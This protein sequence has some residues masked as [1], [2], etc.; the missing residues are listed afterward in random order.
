MTTALLRPTPAR[1]HI[2][3]RFRKIRGRG[4][5]SRRQR[6][7]YPGAGNTWRRCSL[8]FLRPLSL[9]RTSTVTL[10]TRSSPLPKSK[11]HAAATVGRRQHLGRG[12]WLPTWPNRI[13][14]LTVGGNGNDRLSLHRV[15]SRIRTLLETPPRSAYANTEGAP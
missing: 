9:S 15:Q 1:A 7:P 3:A 10:Q 12:R 11:Q 8:P 4:Y 2:Q 6:T 5:Y 14:F 13:R